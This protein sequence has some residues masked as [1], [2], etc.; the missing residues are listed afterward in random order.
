[1]SGRGRTS[2]AP[3]RIAT[4]FFKGEEASGILLM[5]AAAAA[6]VWANAAGDS[7]ARLWQT[8]LPVGVAPLVLAK[9]LLLWINDGLM[10]VFF[11]LVGL[12]I[13]REIRG[14]ELASVRRAALPI[15]AALGGMI[16]P[17]VIY[18]LL[19][20]G[21]PGARGWGIPM[22]TDIAFALGVLALLGRRVAA[23]L[24]IFLA[25]VAIADDLGAVLVIALFYTED[26]S[27]PPIGLAIL[28]LGALAMLNRRGVQHAAPYVLLGGALWLCV[29]TSGV[30]AT[31]AGVA[32]A[33]TI[34]H[35]GDA[36][37]LLH[38]FE[39]ALEPWVAFA[40]LP[41]FALA[42]AGVRLTS[43]I[44]AV[45][46]DPVAVGIVLGLFVGKQ[47]G[48]TAS[49]WVLIRSGIAPMPSGATWR[50]LYSVALRCGIGFTMSLFIA[51]LAFGASDRLEAAKVGVLAGSLLSGIAG[52]L[53]VA[54]GRKAA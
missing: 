36:R 16:A 11:F 10:A 31:I 54:R 13:K 28:V 51:S 52:Y 37:A 5:L 12:E 29:L 44:S 2:S 48:I 3:V 40:I 8:R 47:L 19:N 4:E 9:P 14:G 35:S 49:C 24:R 22:A 20:W 42:N 39:V 43:G 23:S 41:L 53:V 46:L 33:F 50:Q 30:H 34:P 7:Y 38:R 15:A 27:W 32:L 45:A 6:V 21:G 17:A 1:M 26:L 18:G 25:S